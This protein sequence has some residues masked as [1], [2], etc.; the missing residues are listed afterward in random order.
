MI[1]LTGF[2]NPVVMEKAFELGATFYFE[3]PVSLERLKRAL[4]EEPRP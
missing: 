1:I 3:K 4:A 2:G